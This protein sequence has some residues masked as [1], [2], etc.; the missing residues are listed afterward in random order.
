MRENHA[1]LLADK[2]Y[3][4]LKIDIITCKYHPGDSLTEIELANKFNVSR[5]PIRE[6][7]N[8]LMKED[9]LQSIPYKGYIVSPVKLQDLHELYQIRIVLEPY[10]TELAARNAS[11]GLIKRLRNILRVNAK[12]NNNDRQS[13]L[14][15]IEADLDFHNALAEASGNARLAKIM[16]DLRNQIERLV[17]LIY[18]HYGPYKHSG[19]EEHE[20][21][22]KAIEAGDPKLARDMMAKHITNYKNRALQVMAS[23][24][25]M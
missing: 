15:F 18:E 20:E 21:V 7:C 19:F 23:E 4:Q 11:P 25:Q 12:N 10:A 17:F 16:S 14:K 24:R 5:T 1:R 2:I 22:L 6:V 9:F 13:F 8:R 3:E